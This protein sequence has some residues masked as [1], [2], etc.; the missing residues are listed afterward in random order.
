MN[1]V[2]PFND[3]L[4]DPLFDD[5]MMA[6]NPEE[7]EQLEMQLSQYDQAPNQPAV[8]AAVSPGITTN[9]QMP[10]V[11]RD[12][13]DPE[14]MN[15]MRQLNQLKLEVADLRQE[16]AQLMMEKLGKAGE[17]SIV[18]NKLEKVFDFS[19]YETD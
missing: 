10:F 5:F 8:S 19:C 2:V 9:F 17:V 12:H 14:S 4:A 6:M 1:N 3:D 13:H 7:L 18:R 11:P 15:L 16:R